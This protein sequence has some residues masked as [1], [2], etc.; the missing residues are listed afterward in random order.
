MPCRLEL[1]QRLMVANAATMAVANNKPG[2]DTAAAEL[3]LLDVEGCVQGVW[4]GGGCS[5]SR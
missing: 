5:S 3:L 1:L 4:W 2:A